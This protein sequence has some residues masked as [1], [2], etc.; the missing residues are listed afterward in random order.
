MATASTGPLPL[1]RGFVAPSRCS[2]AFRLAAVSRA[3]RGVLSLGKNARGVG[4]APR[5]VVGTVDAADEFEGTG[6][7]DDCSCWAE[8]RF[9]RLTVERRVLGCIRVDGSLRNLFS[10]VAE[11]GKS[12]NRSSSDPSPKLR[13]FVTCSVRWFAACRKSEAAAP[14]FLNAARLDV[15]S[16]L[17][18]PDSLECDRTEGELGRSY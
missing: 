16:A 7:A 18:A 15:P 13:R 5:G 10:L 8:T 14:S 2:R 9:L 12:S 6:V 4:G 17:A 1:G 11:V 3:N